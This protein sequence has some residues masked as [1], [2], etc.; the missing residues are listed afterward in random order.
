MLS[1]M[2][3]PQDLASVLQ[4][5]NSLSIDQPSRR[6]APSSPPIPGPWQEPGS[7]S[8][9]ETSTPTETPEILV[10]VTA[11]LEP[12]VAV[13]RVY[14]D[15]FTERFKIAG[16]CPEV[17]LPDTVTDRHGKPALQLG[18]LVSEQGERVIDVC[19]RLRSWS[20]SKDE[21]ATWLNAL[22][23]QFGDQLRLVIADQT[24]WEI[25][26]ELFWLPAL[27]GQDL[28]AGWLG[29]IVPVARRLLTEVPEREDQ[30]PEAHT[31]DGE[32]VAFVDAEMHA[33]SGVL[34]RYGARC[35]SEMDDLL[36][37][38]DDPVQRLALVYI[39]CHG[40]FNPASGT[41]FRLANVSVFQV[42]N[43]VMQAIAES[44]PLV[45]LNACH[46]ARSI[47]DQRN[48]DGVAHGFVRAFLRN[49]A[50]AV[51]GTAGMVGFDH[52]RTVAN[53]L[54]GRLEQP[55]VPI[56]TALRD[57]RATLAARE[58]AL[59]RSQRRTEE[60]TNTL[61]AFL[62]GFMY[63]YFGSPGTTLHLQGDPAHGEAGLP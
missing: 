58:Q 45:F 60:G 51:I 10:P 50:G 30:P 32:V 22:R 36:D 62:Y 44:R 19:A 40:H 38:L 18:D 52:A 3:D 20:D 49:G 5:R 34:S 61:R 54:L 46:S 29:G 26:W 9:V 17:P 37:L 1:H 24:D 31:C 47:L 41:A 11:R 56:A 39:G 13:L 33:D 53:E 2:A 23:A 25:P 21:L 12:G 6:A 42:Q 8:E 16:D 4:G 59:T 48:N 63:L 28:A 43:S 35:L 7:L 27:P 15:A 55:D 14:R 57:L